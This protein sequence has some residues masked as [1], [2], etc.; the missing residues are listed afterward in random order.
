M[1]GV[2]TLASTVFGNTNCL[3]AWWSTTTTRLNYRDIQ[4]HLAI[5]HGTAADWENVEI[6][7]KYNFLDLHRHRQ[8]LLWVLCGIHQSTCTFPISQSS[9]KCGDRRY[10]SELIMSGADIV[11]DWTWSVYDAIQTGVGYPQLSAVME[12]A[13]AAHG[14]NGHVSDGVAPVRRRIQS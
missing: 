1:D 8:R 10:D 11:S 6:I 9:L 7:P 14:L 12:C 5:R 4:P 2:E 3:L 13:D